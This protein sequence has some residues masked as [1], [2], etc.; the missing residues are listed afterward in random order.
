[1]ELDPGTYE[2]LCTITGH[3]AGGQKATL[4]ITD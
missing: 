1:V 3:Y 2:L 4:E